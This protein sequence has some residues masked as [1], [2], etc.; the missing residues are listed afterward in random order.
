MDKE[1]YSWRNPLYYT[2]KSIL[3][4]CY[5][6]ENPYYK[7]YGGRGIK[8][9]EEFKEDIKC[10]IDY[11]EALPNFKDR[12]RLKLSLDRIDNNTGYEKGNL[13]WATRKQQNNNLR[14]PTGITGENNISYCKK[15]NK[16]RVYK[17]IENKYI[18]IGT[19]KTLKDAI[20]KRD[21]YFERKGIDKWV[22]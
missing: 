4:R 17:H 12:K 2:Y 10:F 7:N 9:S 14:R 3:Y 8:M 19:C 18:H 11:V 20:R 13:R 21:E 1:K 22:S 5:N 16:Y 15:T 6:T